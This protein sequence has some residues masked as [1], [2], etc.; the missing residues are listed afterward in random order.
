VHVELQQQLAWHARGQRRRRHGCQRC[1]GAI[2]PSA[3]LPLP[4]PLDPGLTIRISHIAPGIAPDC[5][6]QPWRTCALAVLAYDC[7][8]E[9]AR[10]VCPLCARQQAVWVLR[11]K[12][13]ST[14]CPHLRLPKRYLS[15]PSLQALFPARV[16]LWDWPR[17][18]SC[19]FCCHP[20]CRLRS[21]HTLP[22]LRVAHRFARRLVCGC[23]HARVLVHAAATAVHIVFCARRAC[24]H[25]S[26]L[27]D[28]V[29][30]WLVRGRT[31]AL[32]SPRAPRARSSTACSHAACCRLQGVL[33]CDCRK[34][35]KGVPAP[36]GAGSAIACSLRQ[37]RPHHCWPALHHYCSRV[38]SWT[39]FERSCLTR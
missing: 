28:C 4:Q 10:A 7:A 24:V 27:L 35:C 23:I 13:L 19:G 26:E 30:Q 34:W 11:L 22:L 12:P 38:R 33:K 14:L 39:H 1:V 6:P 31:C 21:A 2:C 3:P 5:R 37:A 18:R 9:H 8:P 20:Y 16:S 29:A 25:V 32:V 17:A 36:L 15:S